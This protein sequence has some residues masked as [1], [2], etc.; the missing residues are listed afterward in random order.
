MQNRL[1]FNWP[2][3]INVYFNKQ[4]LPATQGSNLGCN[5]HSI[6]FFLLPKLHAVWFFQVLM[7]HII[8]TAK[9]L[10]PLHICCCIDLLYYLYPFL[11]CEKILRSLISAQHQ[12]DVVYFLLTELRLKADKRSLQN[13]V[14]DWVL[15][16]MLERKW[17]G[18]FYRWQLGQMEFTF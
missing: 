13:P 6:P 17:I 1:F 2:S 15:D 16:Y 18:V 8:V 14:L 12:L 9:Y 3:Q 5:N 4:N 7:V 10:D 11:F